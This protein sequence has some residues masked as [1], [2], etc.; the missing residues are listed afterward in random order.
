MPK[1]IRFKLFLTPLLTTLLVVAGMYAFMR[2]SLDRGF[3]D[4]VEKRQRAHLVMLLENLGDYYATDPAWKHLTGNKRKWIELLAQSNERRHHFPLDWLKQALSE[5]L[6]AWPPDISGPGSERRFRPLELRVM[7]L[8]PDK[9]IIFGWREGLAQLSL[10]PIRHEQ[11]IVGYLGV[12]PGKPLNQPIE[13]QFIER[14][15]QSFIWIALGMVLLSAVLALFLAYFIGR[16]L[17]R[18]ASAVKTL[19]VGGY[20]VRL[21]VEAADELGQL[22]RDFNEMAAA[23]EQAE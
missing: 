23:L 10:H 17:K 12:M 11:Q 1:S 18:V 9:T 16:P 8:R 6:D 15:S 21:P 22:A 3:A 5:P 14:Q 19:A 13:L 7:L 20:D 2:W 4:F